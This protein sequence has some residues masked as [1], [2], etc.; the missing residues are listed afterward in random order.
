MFSIDIEVK[1]EGYESLIEFL[2]Q[3]KGIEKDYGLI[4]M[5]TK[6]G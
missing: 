4:E 3:V 2:N 6:R 5:L 1:S